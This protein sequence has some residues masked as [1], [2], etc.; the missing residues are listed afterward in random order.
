M[1]HPHTDFST[2]SLKLNVNWQV[3]FLLSGQDRVTSL[4]P[5]P[6]PPVPAC[7][8]YT[9]VGSFG[10]QCLLCSGQP[11]ARI[12]ADWD[13]VSRAAGSQKHSYSCSP[14]QCSPVKNTPEAR[15]WLPGSKSWLCC[16]GLAKLIHLTNSP[17]YRWQELSG[18]WP[19]CGSVASF[20]WKEPEGLWPHPTTDLTSS[21][22]WE[23]R[24]PA[25]KQLWPCLALGLVPG[26]WSVSRTERAWSILW[27]VNCHKS[28]LKALV[29]V[30]QSLSILLLIPRP[31]GIR[32]YSQ[33]PLLLCVTM[34]LSSGQQDRSRRVVC[35][36]ILFIY[37]LY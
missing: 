7:L 10:C 3:C 35:N 32:L 8:E 34:W 12:R 6:E 2:C 14:R 23:P 22:P 36:F 27:P 9:L 21:W 29:A 1:H 5:G 28:A 17:V 16:W 11:M 37:L 13:N 30:H 4:E 15:P 24:V 26:T 19:D 20:F 31:L 33:T 18:K 25:D